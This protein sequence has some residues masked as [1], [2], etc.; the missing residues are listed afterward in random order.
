LPADASKSAPP[1][2]IAFLTHSSLR[3]SMD[4]NSV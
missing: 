1:R 4:C 3:F 2:V